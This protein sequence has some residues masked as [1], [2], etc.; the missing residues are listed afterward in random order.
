MRLTSLILAA[1]VMVVL[2]VSVFERERLLSFAGGDRDAFAD[3]GEPDEGEVVVVAAPAEPEPDRRVS[4]VAIDSVATPIDRAVL[5]RGQTEAVR[6]VEVRAETTGLVVSEPLRRGARVEA[7]QLLC[8]LDA[9]TRAVSLAEAEARLVEARARLPESQARVREAEARLAEAQARIR[10]AE[11]EQNAATRL[12]EGGFASDARVAGAEASIQAVQAQVESAQAGIESAQAGVEGAQSAIQSAEAAVAAAELE[13]EKLRITAPFDG[14]IESDTA[15]LGALLQAGALCATVI[16]LDPI[17]LV[18][19]VPEVEVDRVTVGA[20]VGG[21]LATGRDVVGRV[22]FLSRSADPTTR[23]FRVEAEV[24]N[25]DLAIR[26]GQTVEM[27]VRAEGSLAHLVPQSALTLDDDGRL[28]MRIVEDG[29]A[30]FV[31]VSI[32]QDGRDG[33]YVSG[34]PD[35]ARIIVVGQEFVTDGVPVE[36]ALREN[37][38]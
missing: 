31:P 25:P 26:D 35:E 28:G 16:Q 18:G 38:S 21:R 29:L 7:G 17:K 6:S 5:L 11:I 32:L 20:D 33:A 3:I 36:V 15:E 14:L 22:T 30:A 24:P 1:V 23:T 8:E 10:E 27:I 12:S 13:I 37:P 9:G 34:L 4:V 2:Y 19:F